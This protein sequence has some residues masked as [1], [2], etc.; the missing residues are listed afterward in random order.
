[1][2]LHRVTRRVA[3]LYGIWVLVCVLLAAVGYGDSKAGHLYAIFTGIPFSILTLKIIP[4]GSIVATFIAGVIGW[5]QWCLLTELSYRY[6]A[7]RGS[8]NAKT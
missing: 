1:M 7:W 6:D 8:K 5:V 2:A 3:I 4:N